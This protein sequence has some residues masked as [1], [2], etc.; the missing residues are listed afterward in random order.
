MVTPTAHRRI[1]KYIALL[2]T[3]GFSLC[4]F[5]FY[6]LCDCANAVFFETRYTG[7]TV[8]GFSHTIAQKTQNHGRV[9]LL[10]LENL[11]LIL[12]PYLS[13]KPLKCVAHKWTVF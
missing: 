10:V 5:D 2:C 7:H 13:P 1:A 3:V 4:Q 8:D 6:S 9:C 11:H 12:N